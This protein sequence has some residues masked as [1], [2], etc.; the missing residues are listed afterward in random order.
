MFHTKALALGNILYLKGIRVQGRGRKVQ[1]KLAYLTM[2][3]GG[4]SSLPP[5]QDRFSPLQS[6]LTIMEG[7]MYD[8]IF[9]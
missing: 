8:G 3:E 5:P 6:E 7:D 9:G 2:E 1:I 4:R